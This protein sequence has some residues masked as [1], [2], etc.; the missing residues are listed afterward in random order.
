[1]SRKYFVLF[2][3]CFLF[4]S[5]FAFRLCVPRIFALPPFKSLSLSLSH[6]SLFCDYY[7]YYCYFWFFF[8]FEI[9]RR[10]DESTV[11]FFLFFFFSFLEITKRTGEELKNSHLDTRS[12][13]VYLPFFPFVCF[14]FSHLPPSLPPPVTLYLAS[15]SPLLTSNLR[16]G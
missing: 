11:G 7:Y 16:N 5:S 6:L 10:H 9:P 12:L 2:F 14:H 4:S 15:F 3:F 8:L 1:M 13:T